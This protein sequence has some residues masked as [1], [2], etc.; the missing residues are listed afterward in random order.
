[1]KITPLPPACFL[2]ACGTSPGPTDVPTSSVAPSDTDTAASVGLVYS[3]DWNGVLALLE[4]RCVSC[5]Q[6]GGGVESLLFPDALVQDLEGNLGVLVQPGDPAGSQL[7][8]VI[9]DEL[10]P[11]DF[12][13]MPLSNPLPANHVEHVRDWII[14][15]ASGP[16]TD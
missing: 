8:R 11:T 14:A 5:H 9:A 15:G 2:I 7:W 4:D 6:P 16:T 1:M 10:A 3:S 13:V 12:G